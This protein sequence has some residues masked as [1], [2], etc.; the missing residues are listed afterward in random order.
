MKQSD[1]SIDWRRE[2]TSAIV[3]KVR[4]A[5]SA[6]GVLSKLLGT[7]CFLYGAHEEDRIKGPPGQILAWRD[8]AICI[9]TL[10]GAV[11]ISHLKAKDNPA[12][13]EGTCR[14][15]Q[16]GVGCGLC[17]EAF[18]AVAGVKLP[19]TQVLAGRLRGVP[20]ISVPIDAPLD[21]RTFREIVYREEEQVGYLS[22]DF[23]NGA[24]STSQCYRLRDA[25][26]HARSRPTRVIVLLGGPDFWSN[27]IHLNTIEASV[28][29]AEESWRNINAIDDLVYEI[30]NTMSQLVIAGLRGNAGAG[31]AILALAADR[32]YAKSGV[33][34]NPHYRGM[35]ELYGSE[36]WTY[37]LPRRVGR[38]KAVELTQSC[39]P[40]GARAAREIGFLDGAFGDDAG[41]FE[42]ELRSRATQLAR[43]P[44]YRLMLREKHERRLD[45][46]TAKPMARYREEELEKMRVNFFGPDPAYHE[47]RG[48]FVFKGNP[49]LSAAR[50]LASKN[51]KDT[52]EEV[53]RGDKFVPA[54]G[55]EAQLSPSPG[56]PDKSLD[57]ASGW[58]MLLQ[59]I[60]QG[61]RAAPL[62]TQRR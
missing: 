16:S 17:D 29:P 12:A 2:T 57:N 8:G 33:V 21:C 30:I 25:F 32:V 14:L 13:H 37:L 56:E 59:R 38:T 1:R 41:T 6:P 45:D 35:G 15:A 5:D 7:S 27:G 47:A 60:V 51:W 40:L 24:M 46:E 34:L 50:S 31:G 61:L 9:G 23:Y 62:L 19:A 48:R 22:F 20:E 3:R 10:D 54:R 18:C 11:W 55:A 49:P 52:D 58:A 43:D 4:A 26:L 53:L 39:Q 36:Y 44:Q 42:K 28:D